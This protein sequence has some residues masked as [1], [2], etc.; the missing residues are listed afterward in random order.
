MINNIYRVLLIILISLTHFNCKKSILEVN[1][2]YEGIW[3]SDANCPLRIE[4]YGSS[5]AKIN[6]VRMYDLCDFNRKGEACIKKDNIIIAGVKYKVIE[7]PTN[8]DTI[9]NYSS[10][11]G[12]H[13]VAK[14]VLEQKGAIGYKIRGYRVFYRLIFI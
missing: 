9:Y 6:L 1:K 13:A 14:M 2:D 8:I 7:P 4:I 3:Y 12:C 11:F 5:K 10:R